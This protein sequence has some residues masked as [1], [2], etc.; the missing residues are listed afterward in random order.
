MHRERWVRR[1]PSVTEQRHGGCEETDLMGSGRPEPGVWPVTKQVVT[2]A[3]PHS[4]SQGTETLLQFGSLAD[5]TARMESD[6]ALFADTK[7][8]KC[9]S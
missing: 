7:A 1:Q 3:G 4:L 6:Q 9:Q 2:G 5:D 8:S